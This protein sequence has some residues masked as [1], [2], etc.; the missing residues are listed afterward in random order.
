MLE[1]VACQRARAYL[2]K[3][4]AQSFIG[5]NPHQLVAA[6][7]SCTP[8]SFV[9]CHLTTAAMAQVLPLRLFMMLNYAFSIW[10]R[11]AAAMLRSETN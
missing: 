7:D 8:C 10:L 11:E 3:Q 6:I 5:A 2:A 1:L 4:C 9:C